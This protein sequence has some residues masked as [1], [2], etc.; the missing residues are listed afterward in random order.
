VKRRRRNRR[1][2]AVSFVLTIV[3]LI[4][5]VAA[6]LLVSPTFVVPSH[7]LPTSIPT[8]PTAWAK[9]VPSN[10]LSVSMI[11]YTLIRNLNSSAAPSENLLQLI[12][13]RENITAA[14]VNSLV[15]VDYTTPNATASMIYVSTASFA[16]IAV[17]LEQAYSQTL[18]SKP[19]FFYTSA[20]EGN[21]SQSGWLALVPSDNIVAFSFGASPARQ[22]I[23][24]CLEAAN[25]TT[26]NLL[27]RSDIKQVFYILNGTEN[28]LSLSVQDFS[29]LVATGNLT[30]LSVDNVGTSIHVSHVVEFKDAETAKSQEGYMRD[31]YL[32][33]TVFDQYD[34]YLT[35]LELRPFS[36][37]QFAVRL[38]G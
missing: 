30:A 6:L 31:S 4:G 17:P 35:A 13:P 18:S 23:N 5:L 3:V 9:Y 32:S 8:Y 29:G 16:K 33:A 21:I 7:S 38:V 37:L 26:S 34:R 15:S 24:L 10:A 19:A 20:K 36:Q 28:H 14:M 22:A 2:F 12:R 25:G 1:L 27:Q 11:N